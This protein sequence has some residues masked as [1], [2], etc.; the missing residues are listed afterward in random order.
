MAE[1]KSSKPITIAPGVQVPA[2]ALRFTFARSG[3]PGGQH[4]NK[5]ST[6]ATLSVP[7]E[8]L[9]AAL[10][11]QT[12]QRLAQHA[13][14]RWTGEQLMLTAAGSRSQHAN[15]R[16]CLVKLRELLV[17]AMHRP[18]PRRPTRPSRAAKQRRL[19]AKRQRGERKAARRINRDGSAS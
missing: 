5:T 13:G 16:A 7:A 18:R 19:E 14:S 11:E 8:A 6:R 17:T 15:R 3:G 9:R 10:S 4:A 12:M 2:S 1:R